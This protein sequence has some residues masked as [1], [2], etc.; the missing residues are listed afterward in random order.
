M[1]KILKKEKFNFIVRNI[2]NSVC[3][4]ITIVPIIYFICNSDYIVAMFIFF[5]LIIQILFLFKENKEYKKYISFISDINDCEYCNC[6]LFNHKI[7]IYKIKK[8]ILTNYE[9]KKK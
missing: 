5:I 8:E 9:K 6:V 7:K 4:F 1:D 2:I 3:I